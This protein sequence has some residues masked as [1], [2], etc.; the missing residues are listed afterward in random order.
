MVRLRPPLIDSNIWV[1][2]VS[3][4]AIHTVNH[5]DSR[6]VCLYE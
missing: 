6:E 2:A 5:F 4:T 1:M 3:N